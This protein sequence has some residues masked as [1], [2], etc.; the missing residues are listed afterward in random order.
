M[1]KTL[2][3]IF[4]FLHQNQ[5]IFF[6]NIGNQNIFLEKKHT[7]WKLNGPSLAASD[8]DYLLGYFFKLYQITSE[9]GRW[10]NN[11]ICYKNI[12]SILKNK[13]IPDIFK[14]GILTP[15]LKKLNDATQMDNYRG[16]TVTPVITKL[17]DPLF[18]ITVESQKAFDVI[19]HII[20]LDKMYETGVHPTLWTIV[21]DFYD[22]LTSKIKWCG[23]IS[24][25][26]PIK[27]GV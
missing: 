27:Q 25:S 7:P 26:F 18:L 21:K 5:N 19:N 15:V 3:Q 11:T 20:M 2:N 6:S 17:F 14:T 13:T 24:E 10:S 9:D 23:D 4:F 22:G 16:I 12:Q 1:T 8:H